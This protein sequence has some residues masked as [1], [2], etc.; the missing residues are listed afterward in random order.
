MSTN[1]PQH[2]EAHFNL[3]D[4]L[5]RQ[6][7][8]LSYSSVV[9]KLE[10][11]TRSLASIDERQNKLRDSKVQAEASVRTREAELVLEEGHVKDA[12]KQLRYL[13]DE[14]TRIRQSL[15]SLVVEEET[16]T[17]LRSIVCTELQKRADELTR[18]ATKKA[19]EKW[20]GTS[21]K[22]IQDAREHLARAIV[23]YA[24]SVTADPR[25]VQPSVFLG[26]LL[27]EHEIYKLVEGHVASDRAEASE[28]IVAANPML[29]G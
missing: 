12:D 29:G 28:S 24:H 1:S 8:K 27:G 4:E 11:V 10:R 14:Q 26:T 25:S 13:R 15:H 3:L 16:N 5:K 20:R 22:C 9:E 18:Q 2:S 21:A 6:L 23:S 17:A 19:Q 7:E